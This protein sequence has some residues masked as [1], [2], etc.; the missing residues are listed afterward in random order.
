M[1]GRQ[2][3]AIFAALFLS[4]HAAALDAS[5]ERHRQ[6]YGSSHPLTIT[7]ALAL[8]AR[9]A[10]PGEADMRCLESTWNPRDGSVAASATRALLIVIAEHPAVAVA[11]AA[12]RPDL[13]RDWMADVARYGIHDV[14]GEG[15][16]LRRSIA[17]LIAT[18]PKDARHDAGRKVLLDGLSAVQV[19][20]LD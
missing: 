11:A 18:T 1:A 16:L 14:N 13:Y 20:R 4:T 2:G 12:Q 8:H 10:T 5:C 9:E 15:R 7:G 6:R 19:F 3:A 17:Q